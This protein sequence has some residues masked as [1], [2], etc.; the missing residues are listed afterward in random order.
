MEAEAAQVRHVL[1]T[2]AAGLGPDS[3]GVRALAPDEQ[4]LSTLRMQAVHLRDERVSMERAQQGL[5]VASPHAHL[6]HP[7]PIAP[8]SVPATGC[9]ASGRRQ[10]AIVIYLLAASSRMT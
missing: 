4:Q 9:S 10:H 1:T 2:R 6:S 3:P 7:T 8:A 5:S